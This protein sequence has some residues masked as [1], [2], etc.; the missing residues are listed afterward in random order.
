MVA[1]PPL[2]AGAP[3]VGN[4][5]AFFRDPV[6]LMR[7]GYR[8][9][10]PAFALKFGPR[11]AAVLVGPDE[12]RAALN[13]PESTLAV[14]PVYQWVKPMFGEVMQAAEHE[15]YLRQRA[16]LLPALQSRNYESYLVAMREEADRWLSSFGREGRFDAADQLETLALRVAVRLF[17]GAEFQ[18]RHGDAFMRMF[19]DI[20]AGMEFFLPANLP[21][22]RLIRRDRAKRRVFQLLEPHLRAVRSDPD[23]AR[24]GFLAH[25]VGGDLPERPTGQARPGEGLEVTSIIGLI[26]ILIYA[27]YETTGAQMAWA[28]IAL[29]QRPTHLKSVTEEADGIL[30][31]DGDELTLKG[32]R[33]LEHLHRCL[34]EVQRLRPVTTMLTRH[35]AQDY[36]VA[37]WSVPAGWQTLFCPPVTHRVPELYPDPDRFDPDRFSPE[38]DP[39]GRSAA[40]L[41]NLGGGPHGCLGGRFA[42]VEM[43]VVLASLLSRFTLELEHPDP[44]A[45]K[46]MGPARPAR[47]CYVHY[48]SRG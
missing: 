27:A 25:L 29:Q 32:L 40:G 12:S 5:P 15:A 43:T 21:I 6:A 1:T 30:R 33:R 38:R 31:A 48:R 24:Y 17:L 34:L 10:G 37:G 26:L 39:D 28:L 46:A 16:A 22:P 14:R 20:A 41:L 11:R 35:T 18:A 4:L 9:H 44:P 47:P 13:L 7:K 8:T 23:P 36:E 2:L 19:R 3:V 42:E 45:A